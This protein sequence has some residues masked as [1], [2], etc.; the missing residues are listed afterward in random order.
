MLLV[1]LFDWC[2]GICVNLFAWFGF[3]VVLFVV[4][5]GLLWLLFDLFVLVFWVCWL[6]GFCVVFVRVLLGGVTGCVS[7]KLINSSV[8]DALC[9]FVTIIALDLIWWGFDV[10]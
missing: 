6:I 3:L 10:C 2:A 1:C 8:Y 9:V 4:L 5:F 7:L